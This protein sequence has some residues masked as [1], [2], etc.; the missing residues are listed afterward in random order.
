MEDINKLPK[1]ARVKFHILEMVNQGLWKDLAAY[2]GEDSSPLSVRKMLDWIPIP[3]GTVRFRL[4]D[5]SIDI[6][7]EGNTLE[8][9]GSDGLAFYPMASNHGLLR[10]TR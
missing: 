3:E 4:P 2:R 7:L 5:G 6:R 10:S 1:W 9:F 8:V